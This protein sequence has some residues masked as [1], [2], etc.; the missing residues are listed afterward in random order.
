NKS[1]VDSKVIDLIKITV[2]AKLEYERMLKF[3]K[4]CNSEQFRP[5]SQQLDE[6]FDRDFLTPQAQWMISQPYAFIVTFTASNFAVFLYFHSKHCPPRNLTPSTTELVKS[7]LATYKIA[8]NTFR[9]EA[10]ENLYA[11]DLRYDIKN[12]LDSVVLTKLTHYYADS[13]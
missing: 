8:Q 3:R 7:Y 1:K 5:T 2:I 13:I 6:I 9:G 10:L 11:N 12:G 4:L